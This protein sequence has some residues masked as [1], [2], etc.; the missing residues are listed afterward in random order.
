MHIDKTVSVALDSKTE[1]YK[2]SHLKIIPV[3]FLFTAQARPA[4]NRLEHLVSNGGSDRFHKV[5]IN[6]FSIDKCFYM[7]NLKSDVIYFCL[8]ALPYTQSTSVN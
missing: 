5:N 1:N 4:N 7:F 8:Q 3:F 6:C 2:S